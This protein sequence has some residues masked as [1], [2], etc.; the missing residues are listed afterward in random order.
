MGAE[1]CKLHLACTYLVMQDLKTISVTSSTT[2]SPSTMGLT[3][4][5]SCSADDSKCIIKNIVHQAHWPQKLDCSLLVPKE[6]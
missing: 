6:Q 5:Q 2:I 1:H 3:Q 4:V